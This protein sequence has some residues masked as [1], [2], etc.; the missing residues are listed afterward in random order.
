[1]Q[2]EYNIIDDE[3]FEKLYEKTKAEFDEQK[4]R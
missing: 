3:E 2:S 1:V 4:E